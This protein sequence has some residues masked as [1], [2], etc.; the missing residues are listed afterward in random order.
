MRIDVTAVNTDIPYPSVSL[1]RS[2]HFSEVYSI[3]SGT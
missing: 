1:L 3:F 2:A